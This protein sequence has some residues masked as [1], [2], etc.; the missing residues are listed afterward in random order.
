MKVILLENIRGLGK[1]NDIREVSDGY[2]RNFLLPKKLAEA[3]TGAALK[4]AAELKARAEAEREK[5]VVGLKAAAEKIK[6]EKLVFKVK[7]GEKGEVFGSVS[8]RDIEQELAGRGIARCEAELK[9]PLKTLGEHDV[10]INF[11]ENIKAKL[12]VFLEN[13]P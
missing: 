8:A 10:E 1:K 13:Q 3:A 9:K 4:R 12:K 2:A 5:L 6:D 11:G 7:T